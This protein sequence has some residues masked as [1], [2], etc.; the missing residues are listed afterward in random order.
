[1]RSDRGYA[2]IIQKQEKATSKPS[3][4]FLVLFILAVI[5][6][7]TS[8]SSTLPFDKQ[9][10]ILFCT[11][12][13]AASQYFETLCNDKDEFITTFQQSDATTSAHLM[14]IKILMKERN[15]FPL[16]ESF[17]KTIGVIL[18]NMPKRTFYADLLEQ[19]DKWSPSK[20]KAKWFLDTFKPYLPEPKLPR[21]KI[22]F[23]SIKCD[24]REFKESPTELEH[25]SFECLISEYGLEPARDIYKLRHEMTLPIMSKFVST[26]LHPDG[27]QNE[28]FKRV[29]LDLARDKICLGPLFKKEY[30]VASET[31]FHP[32][33]KKRLEAFLALL[34]DDA[35]WM[36]DELVD[37]NL[38]TPQEIFD[39]AYECGSEEVALAMIYKHFHSSWTPKLPHYINAKREWANLLPYS[40]ALE[41]Y[42]LARFKLKDA[43]LVKFLEENTRL[44]GAVRFDCP[45]TVQSIVKSSENGEKGPDITVLHLPDDIQL[46]ILLSSAMD[47]FVSAMYGLPLVCKEWKELLSIDRLIMIPKC[48]LYLGACI[49]TT[50]VSAV[51]THMPWKKYIKTSQECSGLVDRAILNYR[52]PS[53]LGTPTAMNQINSLCQFMVDLDHNH[54]NCSLI[55]P[56]CFSRETIV[57]YIEDLYRRDYLEWEHGKNGSTFRTYSLDMKRYLLTNVFPFCTSPHLQLIIKECIRPKQENLPFYELL[58]QFYAGLWTTDDDQQKSWIDAFMTKYVD[59]TFGSFDEMFRRFYDEDHSEIAESPHIGAAMFNLIADGR[60]TAMP[61]DFEEFILI[62]LD[63]IFNIDSNLPPSKIEKNINFI[64]E[65]MQPNQRSAFDNAIL[66]HILRSQQ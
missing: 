46:E 41:A 66:S 34:E 24:Q 61:C 32:D 30:D 65:Q 56:S 48:A 57:A 55:L 62:I 63:H 58:L 16:D 27:C 2:L 26:F 6:A 13:Q 3:M 60:L 23:A 18:E 28:D 8:T 40:K 52:L 54:S 29:W 22:A 59:D 19:L 25:V 1:M 39:A 51:I 35:I 50:S 42:C 47:D 49:A 15:V 14:L 31:I 11:S 4:I 37:S 5:K 10:S 43:Q 45:G 17:I 20:A 44:S 38:V 36:L 53:S 64:F 21:Q 7:V 33:R 9:N 12:K